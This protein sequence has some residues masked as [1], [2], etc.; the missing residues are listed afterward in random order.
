[1]MVDTSALGFEEER[2]PA[3]DAGELEMENAW[4]RF[5]NTIAIDDRY[6]PELRRQHMPCRF[7]KDLTEMQPETTGCAHDH[8][9]EQNLSPN[10]SNSGMKLSEQAGPSCQK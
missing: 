7:W 3:A 2:L 1:S 10:P 6:N 8:S 5:Y 9:E 4:R